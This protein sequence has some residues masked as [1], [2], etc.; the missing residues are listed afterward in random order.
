MYSIRCFSRPVLCLIISVFWSF[1]VNANG[2]EKGP[3]ELIAL[4]QKSAPKYLLEA[5]QKNGICGDFYSRL[6]P[7]L[8]FHQINL[9]INTHYTP[10]KR[11]LATLKEGNNAVYC[12]ASRDE[13]R[14]RIYSFSREP[15][16]KVSNILVTSKNNRH[17]PS[18]LKALKQSGASVGTYFGTGSSHFLKKAGIRRLHERF[19]SVEDGLRSVAAGEIDYFFYHDLGLL[20]SLSNSVLALRPVPTL[21]RSYEH[22]MIYSAKMPASVQK[23]VD[24][25]VSKMVKAGIISD[26]R[27]QYEPSV[28]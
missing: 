3:V 23:I 17:N 7:R 20:Y 22:W 1:S 25:E 5:G 15:L 24:E 4:I 16:Y 28:N 11:I 6:A 12:G 21:F 8:A 19:D 9:R 2:G 26:I 27:K 10:I 14:E 18:S 13:E